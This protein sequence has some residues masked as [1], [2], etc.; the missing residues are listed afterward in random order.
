MPEAWWKERVFY[1][2]YPRSFQD[3]NGDG[4]GDLRG[5]ISRLDYLKS[6]GVGAVWLCPVYDSP[7]ADMGYDIRDYEKIMAEFGTMEDFDELLREMHSRD[8]CLLYTSCVSPTTSPRISRDS[9]KS[10]ATSST[11]FATRLSSG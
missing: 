7:N 5:I 6:L 4:I 11:H 1:Q 3:S 9:R 10:T 2:I 8:I